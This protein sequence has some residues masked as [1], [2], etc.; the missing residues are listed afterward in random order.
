MAASASWRERS[1]EAGKR[2]GR[3]AG[4]LSRTM[5]ASP[6]RWLDPR[7]R[8]AGACARCDA[9]G[10][11]RDDDWAPGDTEPPPLHLQVRSRAASTAEP[12][13]RHRST[14]PTRRRAPRAPEIVA[15]FAARGADFDAVLPARPMRCAQAVSGDV[16]RYVVNRNI[17]YTNICYF[18]CRFCAFSKGKLAREPARR[19]LRP[20]AGR[21]V[22]ARASKP[23]SAAP[24]RSACRAASIPT[25]PARPISRSARR[26][27]GGAGHARPRL[28]AARSDA[29]RRDARQ[30][31][32]ADFLRAP[33]GRRPRHAAG[34]RGRDP[35]RRGARHHLPRQARHPAN[36]ST[37]HRSRARRSACARPRP[38]CSATSRRRALGAPSAGAARPAG[39]TGGFTEF[40]PL[41]FVHMEAPMY[42]QGAPAA[43]RPCA[44]RC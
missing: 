29:R 12:S 28:L 1:A 35:R 15:L 4:G 5:P 3:T 13:P 20:R 8:H 33:E 9:E 42:R 38:S 30:S 37:C 11:A 21:S 16:V 10:F 6:T 40:V 25:T 17:N 43:G 41:P 39:A 26:E 24:P 36:G 18:R 14:A 2:A 27:G 22:A 31:P 32:L 34:H 23:G 7:R 19:A 44:R